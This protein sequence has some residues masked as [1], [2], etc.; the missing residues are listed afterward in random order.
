[1]TGPG[2]IHLHVHSSFSLLEGALRL[3]PLI[4]MAAADGQPALGI[5]DNSNLFGALEFSEKAAEKG[6]QPIVG[7]ELPVEF[8]DRD[9]RPG[10]ERRR[11]GK[12]SLV[13]IAQTA[14]G[15]AN[16]S[17]LVSRAYLEGDRAAFAVPFD[18]LDGEAIADLICL[19]GGPEGA[20]SPLF[21]DGLEAAAAARLAT[22]HSRFGDRLYIELQRHGTDVEARS[23]VLLIE[24]AYRR[25]IPLV[26]TNEP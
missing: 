10:A 7:C 15:F 2:F 19:T 20:I 8:G 17:K 5:A 13:L 16:L 4:D 18:W 11:S 12:E 3:V 21:A 6:I 22:L 25:G 26:A 14:G 23:E 24:A 1:M 9:E